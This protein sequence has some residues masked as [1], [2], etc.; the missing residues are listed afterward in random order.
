MCALS[1]NRSLTC[2]TTT[3][4]DFLAP[5]PLRKDRSA[6]LAALLSHQ[7]VGPRV[8]RTSWGLSELH[9]ALAGVVIAVGSF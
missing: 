1:P 5:R 7:V 8:S 9:E 4:G 6:A 2:C 3:A